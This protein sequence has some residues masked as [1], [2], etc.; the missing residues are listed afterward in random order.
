MSILFQ[1]TGVVI[2]ILGVAYIAKPRQ[3][4]H[5]GLDFLRDPQSEPSEPSDIIIWLYRFI[6]VC[7]VIIGVSYIS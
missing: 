4:Y 2:A 7:L 5:F 6:G 1:L 3:I